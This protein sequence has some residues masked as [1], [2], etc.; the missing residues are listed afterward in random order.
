MQ[1]PQNSLMEQL[2]QATPFPKQYWIAH[3]RVFATICVIFIHTSGGALMRF[4]KIASS[5]WW[6]SNLISGVGRFT[7][8]AFV[9]I[10]GALLLGRE[11]NL[12]AFLQKRFLRVWVPF[13]VWIVIYIAYHNIFEHNPISLKNAFFGYLSGGNGQYGHLWFVYMILGLYLFTPIINFF[14]L[15]ATDLEL[16]Y[17]ITLCFIST[18]LFMFLKEFF[19]LNIFLDI[20]NFGSYLGYF[21]AGY[22]FKNKQ[23]A[24]GK[25]GY[26]AIFIFAYL[27]TVVGTYWISSQKG[28][29]HRYFYDYFSPNT[30]LMTFSIFMFFKTAINHDFLPKIMEPLDKA[31]FGIYLVH[32]LII[33]ILSRKFQINWAWQPPVIGI[34]IHALITLWLSFI[35]V[36]LISKLP[37]GKWLVG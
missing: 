21:V 37:F 27:A 18:T 17:L 11:I 31:S 36:W 6:A 10:S 8:P 19:K 5:T 35:L 12:F 32:L 14:I 16:V 26:L 23:F 3:L 7:V 28:Q 9:M 24:I 22:Y 34:V 13:T 29:Y 15:K 25:Y 20:S 4:G 30:V 33:N 1:N 2:N